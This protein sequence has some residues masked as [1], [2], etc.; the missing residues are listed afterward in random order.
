VPLDASRTRARRLVLAVLLL[1]GG[2][3]TVPQPTLPVP[4]SPSP[5]PTAS[6]SP[7]PAPT[8]APT[9]TP[10][11]SPVAA[12]TN[13]VWL[14]AGQALRATRHPIAVMVDD[15]VDAR[16]QSGLADAD[17]IYQAPAEGGIPRYM[18]LFG[19]GDPP[20]VGPVRSAR[21]YF[22]GW[23]AEWRALYVHA[24]GA[25]NALRA[26]YQLDGDL[27]WNAD[28]FRWGG[29]EGYLWRVSERFSP[30]NIYTSG[31]K[32]Q[33]LAERLG[34][35]GPVTGAAWTFKEPA[36][37]GD[38]PNSGSIV[39]PY[40]GDR[41]S[42]TYDRASD[43]YLRGTSSETTQRDAATGEV[44]APYDVVVLF[45]ASA[46]LAN[47]PLDGD[48][49]AH[50]RLDI[51]YTGSGRALVFR[52]GTLVTARWSK[53]DD[54]SPTR[55][56]YAS[57]PLKGMP[58][59]LVRGQIAVQIVPSSTAVTWRIGRRVTRTSLSD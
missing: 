21:R 56:T 36:A 59:P 45:M 42:Y 32:L 57:G 24:G 31:E 13:G 27:L 18:L 6:P 12:L 16:P 41:I 29:K 43:R 17:V 26:L 15:Q 44:I 22:V 47:D 37:L 19:T 3:C 38:R 20:S 7:S 51:D 33:A 58:V 40:P 23:A 10:T 46:P 35:L 28:A 9:P 34:A 53:K 25:P 48:N 11:P 8:A 2:A 5:A 49:L 30:H 54:A 50:H 55:L 4:G 39:V 52:D 14:P 1:V